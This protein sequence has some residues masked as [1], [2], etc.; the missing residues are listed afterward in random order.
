MASNGNKDP[1]SNLME[2]IQSFFGASDHQNNKTALP[3]KTRFSIWYFLL[4]M[5]LF[6]YLQNV[7]FSA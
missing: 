6:S 4:A 5:L 2:K 1:I 7:F 3:P